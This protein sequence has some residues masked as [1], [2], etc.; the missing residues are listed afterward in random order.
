M[1]PA[2]ATEP[3]ETFL[4]VPEVARQYRLDPSTV[5]DLCRSGKIGAIRVGNGR[6]RWRIPASGIAAYNASRTPAAA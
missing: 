3:Q 1:E 2:N 4:T 5:T 6:G